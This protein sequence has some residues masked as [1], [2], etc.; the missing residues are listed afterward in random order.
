MPADLPPSRRLHVL[1]A[2]PRRPDALFASPPCNSF[3]TG[4]WARCGSTTRPLPRAQRA[5]P[6]GHPIAVEGMRLVLATLRLIAVLQPTCWVIENPRGRLRSLDLLAG[7]PRR[8][9]WYCR[10]GLDRAKAPDLWGVFPPGS[11]C[12]PGATMAAPTTSKAPRGSRTG[13]Q[14]GVS[15]AE[16][17]RIPSELDERFRVA[18]ERVLLGPGSPAAT[19]SGHRRHT[20]RTHCSRWAARTMP[21]RYRGCRSALRGGS[22]PRATSVLHLLGEEETPLVAGAEWDVQHSGSSNE[23]LQALPSAATPTMLSIPS[24]L[25]SVSLAR[26]TQ[27]TTPTS[28]CCC[29]ERADRDR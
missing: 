17:G 20:A 24:R 18:L 19:S 29:L 28:P 27:P 21:D 8:T 4:P 26:V 1:A 16:A 3:G 14:G 15:T 9:V 6:D 10:L 25:P 22:G 12:R 5:L 2:L 23:A 7:I 13:T 11:S